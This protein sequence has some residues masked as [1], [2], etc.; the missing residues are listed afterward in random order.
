MWGRGPRGNN[1]PC[2]G[3]GWLSATSS[4]THKQVRP[5]WCWF[6][7]WGGCVRSRTLWVSPTNFPGRLGISPATSTPTD[8]FS[9]RFR[10]FPTMGPWVVQSVPLPSCSG[11]SA[12]ICGIACSASRCLTHPDPPAATLPQVLSTP[13]AHLCPSYQFGWIFFFN[14]LAG[15]SPY[16]FDFVSSGH[17]LFLNLLSFFWLCE[18]TTCI[19]LSLHL[20]WK[21]REL[22]L[23]SVPHRVAGKRKL[24]YYNP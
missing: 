21:S 4:T 15:G 11:L 13:A 22:I 7:G 12:C 20:G 17:V 19:Y 9:Q 10:G 6:P 1:A 16:K 23:Q 18:E 8:F 5:F 14:S 3:F 2:S 24:V